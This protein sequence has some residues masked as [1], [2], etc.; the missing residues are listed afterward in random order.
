MA[1]FYTSKIISGEITTFS[2]FA[3]M[4]MRAFSACIHQCDED[5]NEPPKLA[6]L[7][8]EYRTKLIRQSG[9]S[10]VAISRLK[11][12]SVKSLRNKFMKQVMEDIKHY[13]K[14]NKESIR[15][16]ERCTAILEE[17]RQYV[18]PTTDHN[19]FKQ[20]LIDQLESTIHLDGSDY[21]AKELGRIAVKIANFNPED[22]RQSQIN[23]HQ[24]IINYN[25]KELIK[26]D[27]HV[28][29]QNA[30]ITAAFN[31]INDMDKKHHPGCSTSVID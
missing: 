3:K 27:V 6:E 7:D 15:T 12:S 16:R 4:Y 1:T 29:N 2:Q 8:V 23:K 13:D 20:S 14:L 26:E 22:Y 21:Y 19:N 9:R 31:S 24:D 25:K 17:A 18:P 10:Q 11:R 30:W 28:A 5:L